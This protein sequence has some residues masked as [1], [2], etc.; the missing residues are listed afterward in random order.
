[1][2]VEEYLKQLTDQIRCKKARQT[3]EGEIRC[4][5]EDQ[6]NAY[7]EGGM[8]EEEAEKEAVRQMGDPIETGN[9]LNRI[10]KPRM[11]WDMVAMV[12]FLSIAGLVI[13]FFLNGICPVSYSPEKAIWNMLVGFV[14]M[15]G[16]CMIDYSWIGKHA[17]SLYVI[18]AC[19][20]LLRVV[21]IYGHSVGICTHILRNAEMLIELMIPLY[22]AVLFRYRGG[23]YKDFIKCLLFALP[24][25]CLAAAS[26]GTAILIVG[27]SFVV[28][29]TIAVLKGW[30]RGSKKI[31]LSGVWGGFILMPGVLS[32]ALLQ[33]GA[34]YQ[35]MRFQ[36]FFASSSAGFAGLYGWKIRDALDSASWMG[37]T[38]EGMD[39]SILGGNDYTL[40]Y[41]VLQFGILIAV[42]L[43]TLMIALFA[44]GLH[45]SLAQKNQLGMIMGAG[46]AVGFLI[47]FILYV[48]Y[49]TGI[50][51]A[52]AIYC[53]FI[54]YGGSG[55]LVTYV[56]L[57]LVLSVYRYQNVLAEV[58]AG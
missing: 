17:K 26:S 44:K 6:K 28:L 15:M 10:H 51:P 20:L 14:I 21:T 35:K 47:Q 12:A 25:F 7:M 43:V 38:I 36:S 8:E 22:G 23:G 34:A 24:V 30:F 32:A 46:C 53:P 9:E 11:A 45:I 55:A 3:V 33:F 58:K 2:K 27:L 57:G 50:L 56:L 37:S 31:L 40:F 48:L 18:M 16:V 49:N 5:I 42:L 1:M 13:Q 41:L 4:H 39:W 19:I 54:T 29:L 52:A